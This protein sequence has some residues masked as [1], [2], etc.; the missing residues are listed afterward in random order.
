[1]QPHQWWVLGGTSG[2]RDITHHT[3]LSVVAAPKSPKEGATKGIATPSVAATRDPN[4]GT[5][6]HLPPSGAS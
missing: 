5:S 4:L 6:L 2:T 1:M 3:D